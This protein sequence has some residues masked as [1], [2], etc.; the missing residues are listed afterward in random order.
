MYLQVVSY[1]TSAVRRAHFV[2]D[3]A[4]TFMIELHQ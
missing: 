2:D 3:K 1:K 4:T